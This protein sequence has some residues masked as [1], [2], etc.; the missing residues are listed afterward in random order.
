MRYDELEWDGISHPD[1]NHHSQ[2]LVPTGRACPILND[3][4]AYR[5]VRPRSSSSADSA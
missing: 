4:P 1:A 3:W 5:V 2:V